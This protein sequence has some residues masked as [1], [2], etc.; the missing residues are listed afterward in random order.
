MFKINAERGEP[1]LQYFFSS[2]KYGLASYVEGDPSFI[3]TANNEKWYK[4]ATLPTGHVIIEIGN[5][6]IRFEKNGLVED[7]IISEEAAA[8]GAESADPASG[9]VSS[10]GADVKE[11]KTT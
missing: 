4:G 2:E 8:E 9:E 1:M 11:R 5:G 7:L 10:E 3:S 6:R